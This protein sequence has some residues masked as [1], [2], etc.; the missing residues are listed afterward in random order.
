MTQLDQTGT[1]RS[2]LLPTD[3][4]DLALAQLTGHPD[5]AHTTPSVVQA[6]DFYG[7]TTQ[8]I[9]QTVKWTEGTSV[10]ITQ[11]NAGPP[12][13]IVL[14]PKVMNA[15]LRQQDAVTAIVRRR[16][17]RRLMAERKANG[18]NPA[19]ALLDPAVRAKALKARKAKAAA[20][21]AR[22]EARSQ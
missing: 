7:N 17:G 2:P 5:G 8:F 19:A 20:R 9:I 13:R 6:Q 15:V 21:R 4:F 11:I 12:I 16:L 18:F 22:R 14:P 10:F 3:A 1:D